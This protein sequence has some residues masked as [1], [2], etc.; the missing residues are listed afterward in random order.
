MSTSSSDVADEEQFFFTRTDGQDETEEKI[1][2]RKTQSQKKAV[3]WVV[4]QEPSSMKPSIKNFTEIDGNTT[5]YSINGIKASAATRA[6][7]EVDLALKNLKFKKFGPPHD[8]VLLT[9]DRRFKHWKANEVHITLKDGIFFR[10]YYGETGSV[11]Y[12][13]SL[14]PKQPTN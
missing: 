14:I 5:S 10:E 7:Q 4:K 3:E 6:E 13:K 11:K 12:Y 9:T 8:D 2:Q 1:L